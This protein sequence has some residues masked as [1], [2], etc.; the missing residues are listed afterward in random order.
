MRRDMIYLALQSA[1]AFIP[2]SGISV[3]VAKLLSILTQICDRY[4]FL[5]PLSSDIKVMAV[6]PEPSIVSSGD[7]G[8]V[9]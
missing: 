2:V 6:F 8:G 7:V 1:A 5:R 9:H 4:A 3:A